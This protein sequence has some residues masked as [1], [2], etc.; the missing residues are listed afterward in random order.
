MPETIIS[1]TSCIILLDKIG[2]LNLLEKVYNKVV[3]TPEILEE[4]GQKIPDWI[5]V[6]KS[7]NPAIQKTLEQTLDLGEAS[8]I[9]LAFD[10]INATLIIDDLKARKIAKSL[11]FKV[12]GTL[13][14]I[15]RAKE[16][17]LIEHIKPLINQLIHED[18]R[19][20]QNVVDE[21]LKRVGE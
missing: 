7:S 12:T 3:I 5:S 4:F 1:D 16:L 19:I 10:L 21:I 2:H 15:V 9:S 17:G 6:K 18:F 14:V 20:S 13:G 8:A 11:N